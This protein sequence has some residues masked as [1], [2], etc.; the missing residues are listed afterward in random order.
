ML[1]GRGARGEVKLYTSAEARLLGVV[2]RAGCQRSRAAVSSVVRFHFFV[3]LSTS[4]ELRGTMGTYNYLV[5]AYEI[6]QLVDGVTVNKHFK[7]GIYRIIAHIS[8]Q[9]Y[10]KHAHTQIIA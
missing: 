10:R 3:C 2:G 9:F 6:L 1:L 8:R 7:L 5:Y 4:W